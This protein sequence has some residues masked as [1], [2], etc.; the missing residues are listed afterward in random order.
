MI[1]AGEL[2]AIIGNAARNGVGGTQYCGVWSLCNRQRPFN[3]FGNAFAGLIPDEIR[4]LGPL[5]Q[6]IDDQ[7]A[8]L[9]RAA[10]ARRPVDVTATYQ[11]RPPY[12]LD[13]CMT[14]ID[15]ESMVK[16][17]YPWREAA[18][19]S[20]I[21]CP[22]DSR[23]HYLSRGEWHRYISPSHG[24][25]CNIPPAFLSQKDLERWPVPEL[26][27]GLPYPFF[28]TGHYDHGF[29]QPFYYGRV[30]AMVLIHVFD[31]PRRLRFFCSP[32]GGGRSLLPAHTCPAW[33]FLWLIPAAEYAVNREYTFRMRLIYKQ[34][35]SDEDV[36][37]EVRRSQADLNFETLEQPRS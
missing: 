16:P 4:G 24:V 36:L 31:Q 25:A 26:R 8:V 30:G 29:D 23:L 12:Y 34:F 15:R 37:D 9:H 20:Y 19:C 35:V 1:Q 33:D 28:H 17:E 11:L 7:K 3:V 21:N 14:I 18:W 32:S 2:Q 13:H 22:E 27:N 5:L 10:D 6:V